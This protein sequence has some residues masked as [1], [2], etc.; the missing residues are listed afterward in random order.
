[1]SEPLEPQEMVSGCDLV[2]HAS[3]RDDCWHY[4]RMH[5][6]GDGDLPTKFGSFRKVLS[7]VLEGACPCCQASACACNPSRLAAGRCPCCNDR[8]T[9]SLDERGARVEGE[10]LGYLFG[11]Y[12]PRAYLEGGR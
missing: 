10:H 12:V 8:F 11:Y 1:M 5:A 4:H 7:L 2:I 6:D 9:A 3:T